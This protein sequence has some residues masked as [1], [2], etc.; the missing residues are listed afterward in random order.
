[1]RLSQCL[2]T[3]I[4]FLFISSSLFANDEEYLFTDYV[5]GILYVEWRLDSQD[6]FSEYTIQYRS[7]EETEW[8]TLKQITG[9]GTVNHFRFEDEVDLEDNLY[10]LRLSK[11]S[12]VF[13]TKLLYI[14]ESQ[15]TIHQ[16]HNVLYL[17]CQY[18]LMNP[19][20]TVLDAYGNTVY[21]EKNNPTENGRI[22]LKSNI[23]VDGLYFIHLL[24]SQGHRI[25]GELL[26]VND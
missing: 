1:M 8:R 15:I 22:I 26:I 10:Y 14:G 7:Y 13:K 23:L 16:D 3:C 17:S 20:V 9:L 18:D 19:Q 25:N 5:D 2:K 11:G 4:V 6:D 24:N 21:Y 12:E